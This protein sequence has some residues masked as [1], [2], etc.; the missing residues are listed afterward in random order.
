MF[1]FR[2]SMQYIWSGKS[3]QPGRGSKALKYSDMSME[4]NPFEEDEEMPAPYDIMH[5]KSHKNIFSG[6]G[7]E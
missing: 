7:A 3:E 6:D 5:G 2:L 4:F 1:S